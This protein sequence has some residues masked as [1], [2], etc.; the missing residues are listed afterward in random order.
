VRTAGAEVELCWRTFSLREANRVPASPSPFDD[1]EDASVSVLALALAHAVREADF[2]RYHRAV[3]RA[4][5]VEHRRL[6]EADLL[7]MAAG[8]GVDVEHL[9]R[10]RWL[11]ALA[12]EHREAAEHL[13]VFGTPTLV[14]DGEAVVFLKLAEPP[15][16]GEESDL[17]RSLCTLARC[18]PELLEIKRAAPA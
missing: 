15:V 14:L 16:E 1:P 9:D 3:F 6:G 7:E 18:H 8:A 17:W 4:M 12:G 5:H 10:A 11:A 13:G 2:D